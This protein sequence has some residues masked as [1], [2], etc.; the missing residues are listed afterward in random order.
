MRE[1]YRIFYITLVH[2]THGFFNQF[3]IAY[4]V[5]A[6]LDIVGRMP[7]KEVC[8]VGE[9]DRRH[10]RESVTDGEKVNVV[11]AAGGKH[12]A[13]HRMRSVRNITFT[14]IEYQKAML[15]MMAHL[16]D[17]IKLVSDDTARAFVRRYTLRKLRMHQRDVKPFILVW[18]HDQSAATGFEVAA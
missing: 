3:I 10:C 16:L 9:E 14:V 8:G 2:L 7:D 15:E 4:T 18:S 12:S 1:L 13:D 11:L 17:I 5:F 6:H